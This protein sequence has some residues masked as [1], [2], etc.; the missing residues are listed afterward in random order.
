MNKSYKFAAAISVF[1]LSAAAISPAAAE[2]AKKE[3]CYGIVKSGK[4]DCAA[5]DSS[6][7]CAT[8][9]TKDGYENDWIL[10]PAGTCERIIG[11]KIIEEEG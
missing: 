9:S 6:H 8:Y 1:A 5:K 2:T 4:N 3:K 7:A 11:G 10:L